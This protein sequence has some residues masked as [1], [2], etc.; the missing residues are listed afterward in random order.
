MGHS[1]AGQCIIRFLNGCEMV[2]SL[3]RK[4]VGLEKFPNFW[5]LFWTQF[6]GALNDNFLKQALIIMVTYQSIKVWGMSGQTLNAFGAGIFILP[7]FLFSGLA[8]QITDRFDKSKVIV[9][10]KILEIVLMV[11]AAVGFYYHL[12]E[13]LFVVLFFMAVHSTFFGP[14]KYSIIPEIVSEAKLTG[15]NAYVEMGTFVAIL[16]GNLWGGYAITRGGGAEKLVGLSLIVIA[17]IG[18]LTSRHQ[19]PVA[20]TN[21]ELKIDINPIPSTVATIKLAYKDAALFNSILGISWFWFLGAAILTILPTYC[22]DLMRGDA[23]VVNLFLATFTIGIAVGSLLAE[24]LSF[25][26]VE[27]GLVP[28]GAMGLTVTLFML[29]WLRPE[30]VVSSDS[31]HYIT[32]TQF[33]ALASGRKIFAS[34][35][36]LAVFAGLYTVPLYTLV[37][38]RSD[39]KMRSQIVASNN[40]INAFFMVVSSLFLMALDQAQVSSYYTFLIY[41]IMN[42]AV[43][44]YIY[45]LVPDFA[46]RFI[47]WGIVNIMYRLK[48]T[49]EENIPRTGAVILASNHVSF[50]DGLII[51]GAV[52]RPVRF[53]MDYLFMTLP[54]MGWFFRHAKIIPIAPT[55]DSAVMLGNAFDNI[56]QVIAKGD[57]LGI[58]PEGKISRDGN[59]SRFRRGIERAIRRNPTVVVPV[60]IVGLW[61]SFFSFKDGP[62][63][64]KRPRRFWSRVEL[65]IGKPIPASEVTAALVESRVRELLG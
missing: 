26:R 54:F 29:Y 11:M 58:F 30:W 5:P 17:I 62:A 32:W 45:L 40:I 12:F 59:L 16:L 44:A 24:K 64:K 22:R 10:T 13:F 61:G 35:F 51:A 3:I 19:K 36:L 15:A 39:K 18:Y 28:I 6:F 41:G 48:V 7:F 34:L 55:K 52:K 33:L 53:V 27:I 60:A 50:V 9:A 38:S 8:G 57:V 47:T 49:G 1:A 20:P 23:T 2:T 14:A 37:Q 63:M 43:S 46:L 42:L 25:D 31:S 65:R 4:T 56:S 21:P